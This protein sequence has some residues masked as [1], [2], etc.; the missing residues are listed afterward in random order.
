MDT[1]KKIAN[2]HAFQKRTLELGRE[3]IRHLAGDQLARAAGGIPTD[4]GSFGC[5]N[6]CTNTCY[7]YCNGCGI[8]RT[9][10]CP[11]GSFGCTVGCTIYNA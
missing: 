2:K 8:T 6:N 4:T 3:T 10:Q 7:T 9:D 11:S 5:T 1:M